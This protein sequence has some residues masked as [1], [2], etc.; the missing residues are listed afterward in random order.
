[1]CVRWLDLDHRGHG[2]V[3]VALL[4]GVELDP[5][6]QLVRHPLAPRIDVLGPQV[7]YAV[8]HGPPDDAPHDE[9][10][11]AWVLEAGDFGLVLV[12]HVRGERVHAV[13][14][15][16]EHRLHHGVVQE[17][18]GETHAAE[19]KEVFAAQSPL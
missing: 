12:V 17:V 9:G 7:G 13:Q 16:C 8:Q 3:S 6:D 19:E 14:H 4:R 10:G 11:V 18:H 2:Q 5:L 1:M 15:P